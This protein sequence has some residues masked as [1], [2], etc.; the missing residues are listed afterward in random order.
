MRYSIAIVVLCLSTTAS[1]QV[2]VAQTATGA[3]D[4]S[5]WQDA[6]TD[7]QPAL[8]ATN[9]GEVWVAAGTYFPGPASSPGDS[10]SLKS[11]VQVYGG[12]IGSETTLTA[13][14]VSANLTVLSGDIDQN[15]T[16]GTSWNWW[17]FAWTGAGTNSTQ[18]VRVVNVDNTGRLDGFT[19]LAG[20]ASGTYNPGAGMYL[21]NSSPTLAN[22]TWEK[23][24]NGVGS[25]MYCTGG[26]PAIRSC[27]VKDGYSFGKGPSGFFFTGGAQPTIE[28]SQFDNHYVVTTG[29][30]G[31]GGAVSL[32]FGTSATIKRSE[33][34]RNQTGN[35][36]AMGDPSGSFGGGIYHIGDDLLV[37]DCLFDDNFAHAGAGIYAR[38]NLTVIDSMFTN[39]YVKPYSITSQI[40]VG[41]EGAGIYGADFSS[42]T[43]T[44]RIE[45]CTF[46]A[47]TAQKAA[48]VAAYY[49]QKA[50]I[51][52][53]I[54]WGNFG[55]PAIPGEDVIWPLKEQLT[56]KYDLANSD[57][58]YLFL[59]EPGEDPPNPASFPGCFDADPLFAPGGFILDALSPCIDAGDNTAV[60][61]GNTLD[62][63]GAARFVDDPS[64]VDTGIG[65]AP[66]VDLGALERQPVAPLTADVP[67][68]SLVGGGVQALA[69]SAPAH[70]SELYWVLGSITGTSPGIAV[71]GQM[72]PLT[73]DAY[74][75][76]TLA[77]PNQAHLSGTLG[78][79]DT[80][81]AGTAAIV[82]PPASDPALAGLTL[83]HA[84]VTLAGQVTSASNA[85]SLTLIP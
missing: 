34:T 80:S 81:G 73:L 64:V 67:S 12:F 13:R 56:G 14:D 45:G 25:S 4:G 37:E 22:L 51:R 76:Q 48:G 6:Y 72:I 60:T 68:L 21:E 74:T 83:Y 7:L 82:I 16:Y 69:L 63:V 42:G 33:F 19:I 77:A 47:N 29:G 36:F 59:T 11:G 53:T 44:L 38:K 31:R 8:Q 35:W 17:Q 46:T 23:N 58:Y 20:Y 40:D 3:G 79:L 78:A 26:Q 41:D 85:V 39:N 57:V 61:T 65:A 43:G 70:P 1:A 15:D 50:I 24:A 18:I 28:D 27:V 84:F 75:L 55:K 54:I 5:S 66:V 10:F 52:N 30:S 32:D 62:L 71:D 49:N 9:S 2:F